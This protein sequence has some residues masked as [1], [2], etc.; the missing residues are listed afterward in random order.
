MP[1]LTND[2]GRCE[3]INLCYGPRGHGPYL[4]RQDGYAPGGTDFTPQRHILLRDGS[5]MRNLVFGMMSEAEQER[6]VLHDL[7]EVV[8]LL[9][10]IAC[11]PV[12]VEGHLPV[13]VDEA[14]VLRRFE[15]CTHRIL[16]GMDSCSV[17]PLPPRI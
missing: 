17:T 16:R 9:D 11:R 13:G 7:A 5:W 15:Q 14:E 1:A 10:S 4:V 8:H 12:V 6:N 2:P 3:V